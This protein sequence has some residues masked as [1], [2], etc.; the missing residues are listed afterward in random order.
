MSIN[1]GEECWS[2]TAVKDKIYIG[3]RDKVIILNIDGSLVR[4]ITTDHICIHD[5][6]DPQPVLALLICRIYI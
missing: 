5:L 3:G 4:E 1:I 6:V 2:V